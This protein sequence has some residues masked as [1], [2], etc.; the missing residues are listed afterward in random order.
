VTFAA[1]QWAP[2]VGEVA[3]QVYAVGVASG[4]GGDA[5]RVDRR[6]HEEIDAGQGRGGDQALGDPH[7]CRLVAVDRADDEDLQ[8]C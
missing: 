1:G 7:S 5:V 4:A 6:D 3:V 2:A 8:R